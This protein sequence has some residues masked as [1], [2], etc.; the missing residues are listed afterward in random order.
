[1]K[2]L[3]LVLLMAVSTFS[4]MSQNAKQLINIDPS[5]L[6]VVQKDALTGVAIDQIS[7]D[8][9]KRQCAR[10]KIHINRMTRDE[11]DQLVVYPIG[12]NIELTKKS[13]SYEGNGLI[14]ELTAKEQTR[15][16]LHHDKY[17]D[18]NE[19]ALNL[20]G[21]KEYSLEAQLDML[22]PIVVATNVVGADIFLDKV[23]KGITDKNGFLTIENVTPGKHQ[24][25]VIRDTALAKKSID[26][27]SGNISFLVALDN[28]T[29][30]STTTNNRPN[31][32]NTTVQNSISPV[33]DL[34][35]A[36]IGYWKAVEGNDKDL[37]FTKYGTV[38]QWRFI[39]NGYKTN[40]R[41]D[42]SIKGNNCYIKWYGSYRA[43]ITSNNGVIWLELYGDSEWAGKYEKIK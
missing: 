37:E 33:S 7:L 8:R 13:T 28:K 40:S 24:I 19:V 3:I 38:I 1:M 5:S 16:Y 23:Y 35:T 6:K 43:E 29:A 10:I 36:I 11:I 25:M 27:S 9:S 2:R 41:Y 17:G 22:L 32:Q 12:G 26:V 31:T 14:I 4:V 18:S 30:E 39:S 20:T 34:S 21:G 15:F 42:Y